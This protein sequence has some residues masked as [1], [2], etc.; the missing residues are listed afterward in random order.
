MVPLT[1]A[2]AVEPAETP[3]MSA[4]ESVGH[5]FDD[6]HPVTVLF[7]DDEPRYVQA[8]VDDL[9]L[10]GI[11][12]HVAATV[13]NALS[14]F[15]QHRNRIDVLITDL[16]IIYDDVCSEAETNAC[17]ETGR[18]LFEAIR[19]TAPALPVVVFTNATD[20]E[21]LHKITRQPNCWLVSKQDEVPR[22]LTRLV[23]TIACGLPT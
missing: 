1:W 6:V 3:K 10:A 21:S 8:Y 7:V 18:V 16:I 23:K 2:H 20:R 9:R 17:R 13:G 12:V 5:G 22:V 14:L 11:T 15:E 19:S 4:S